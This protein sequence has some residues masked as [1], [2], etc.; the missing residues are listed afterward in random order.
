MVTLMPLM[1]ANM[2]RVIE[3]RWLNDVSKYTQ[4]R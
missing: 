2:E 4:I 3:A 1:M